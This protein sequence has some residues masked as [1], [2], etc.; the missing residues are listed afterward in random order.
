MDLVVVNEK[1]QQVKASDKH[2]RE[3]L[4]SHNI[5]VNAKH[6]IYDMHGW[7]N[8]VTCADSIQ[9]HITHLPCWLRRLLYCSDRMTVLV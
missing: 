8:S 5:Q 3:Y 6:P 7:N 9:A 2:D 1:L 4:E